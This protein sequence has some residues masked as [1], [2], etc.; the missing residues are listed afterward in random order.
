MRRNGRSDQ[1]FKSTVS[2]GNYPVYFDSSMHMY[3][4]QGLTLQGNPLTNPNCKIVSCTSVWPCPNNSGCQ[5]EA[6][7]AIFYT[8]VASGNFKAEEVEVFQI[9]NSFGAL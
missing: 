7:T 2:P 9:V 8:G 5:T 4:Q 1:T 3:F 6:D